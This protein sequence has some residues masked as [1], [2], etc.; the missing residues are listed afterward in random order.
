LELY[1]PVYFSHRFRLLGFVWDEILYIK[2][3]SDRVWLWWRAFFAAESS[4]KIAPHKQ[5][6]KR[7][8]KETAG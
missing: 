6:N 1:W 5:R 3:A 4:S 2:S 8:D 7:D